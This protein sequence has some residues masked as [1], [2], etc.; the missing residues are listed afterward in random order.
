MSDIQPIPSHVAR[1]SRTASRPSTSAH[2]AQPLDSQTLMVAVGRHVRQ[3]RARKNLTRRELS[4]RTDISERYLGEV[5]K[6]RANVTLA[7]LMRIADILGEPMTAFLPAEGMHRISPPLEALI[8]RM[9][10]DDQAVLYRNLLRETHAPHSP[11][12]GIALV[13]LRGAGKST[14]GGMLAEAANVP[15]VSLT[16]AIQDI[17]GMGLGEMLELMGPG[18]YR[19]IERRALERIIAAHPLAVIEAGGGLVLETDTFNL[20]MRSYRTIWLKASPEEH[21]QRVIDQGDM[22]PMAG[23]EQAMDELRLILRERDPYYAQAD[24]VLDTS[25]QTLRESLAELKQMCRDVLR[26]R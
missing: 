21:M 15:F 19:R 8:A 9:S 10:A 4:R 22:R 14:L 26:L 18:A 3:C 20:L 24:H 1:S 12:R 6:G 17:A 11:V 13:G 2:P 7:L 25:G 5:E 23:N 16:E